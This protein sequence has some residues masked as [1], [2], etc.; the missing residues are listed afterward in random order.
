MQLIT[1]RQEHLIEVKNCVRQGHRPLLAGGKEVLVG[2]DRLLQ[3][4][5]VLD[6]TKQDLAIK[7]SQIATR[8][9]LTFRADYRLISKTDGSVLDKGSARITTKYNVLDETF[10]TL[11]AEKDARTRAVREISAAIATQIA[12]F[13]ERKGKR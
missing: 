3:K 2:V 6:E 12:V 8:A 1:A 9:N 5:V 13:F 7:K 10:A 11:M 4:V